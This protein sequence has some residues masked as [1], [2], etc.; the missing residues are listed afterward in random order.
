MM[1]ISLLIFLLV[2]IRRIFFII[3][4]SFIK[5]LSILYVVYG[6]SNLF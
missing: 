3:Y 4:Y 1:F 2:G 6:F 5:V